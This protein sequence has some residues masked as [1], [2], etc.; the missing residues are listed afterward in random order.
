VDLH[1]KQTLL[2]GKRAIGLQQVGLER[3]RCVRAGVLQV[4]EDL[5]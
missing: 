5:G 3:L 2:L 1:A 4:D